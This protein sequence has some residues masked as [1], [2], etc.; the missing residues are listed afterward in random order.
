MV[1][2]VGL[3]GYTITTVLMLAI[4]KL[5]FTFVVDRASELKQ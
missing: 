3:P 2:K 5:P 1:V 4:V